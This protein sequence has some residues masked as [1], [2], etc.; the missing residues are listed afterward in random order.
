MSDQPG[1]LITAWLTRQLDGATSEWLAGQLAKLEADPSDRNLAITLGMIPR[2]LGKGDLQ[3]SGDDLAAAKSARDGWDP[4]GWS[5]DEAARILAML[6]TAG[7]NIPFT[8]RFAEVC[9]I[10]EIGELMALYRGLL[11]YPDQADLVIQARE[12]L[13]SNMR[14]V[15][16]A[17][18]HDNPFPAEHFDE[19]IWNHMVLKALFVDSRLYPIQGLDRR[20]N[21]EL[22]R[23]MVD[24]AHERW[25]AG[26][27]VT[28]EIW[29]CVGPFAEGAMV[30]DLK[31]ALQSDNPLE[32]K[33]AALALAA[34]PDPSAGEAL[35]SQAELAGDI[36]SG[37]LT[38]DSLA[39]EIKA[40]AGA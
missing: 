6:K 22:A 24:Y 1:E 23:I 3:L 32:Q 4:S 16:E 12:G 25:A 21:P 34:A 11:L 2:K 20:A 5:V 40:Q 30:D 39:E 27:P 18:A 36:E 17:I 8:E 26:R 31:R 29:R 33:A 7:S 28:P 13:R 38:W 10:A 37:T 35:A 15:F 14:A 9:R 19:H